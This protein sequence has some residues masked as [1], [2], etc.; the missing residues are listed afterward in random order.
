MIAPGFIAA[1]AHTVMIWGWEQKEQEEENKKERNV[2]G[3]R[4]RKQRDPLR[5]PEV[6]VEWSSGMMLSAFF[7]SLSLSFT[8]LNTWH[9]TH[10]NRASGV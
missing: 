7:P 10:K 9:K 6:K 2:T 3:N 5:V 8:A 4:D 1:P